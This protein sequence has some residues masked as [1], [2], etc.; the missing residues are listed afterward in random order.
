MGFRSRVLTLPTQEFAPESWP[1]WMGQRKRWF[2]GW[3]QTLLV[4]SRQP[5]ILS[6]QAGLAAATAFVLTIGG[7]LVSALAHPF[8]IVMAINGF[9]SVSSGA[10]PRTF[11]DALFWIDVGNLLASYTIFFTLGRSCLSGSL[12]Q[13]RVALSIPVY[14]IAMSFAAWWGLIELF[15]KPHHWQKTPHSPIQTFPVTN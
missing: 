4:H 6:R 10:S 11:E 9:V 3:M 1:I 15:H 14:W 7:G 8:I 2:K 13:F 12:S 5:I